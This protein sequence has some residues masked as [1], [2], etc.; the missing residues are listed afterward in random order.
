M[1][2]LSINK[3]SNTENNKNPQFKS[4][5]PVYHWVEKADRKYVVV[6]TKNEIEKMQSKLIRMLNKTLSR[7][8]STKAAAM[9]KV[10]NVVNEAD[11]DYR[12]KSEVR[13]FY[14]PKGGWGKNF[15]APITYLITGKDVTKFDETY[16]K[17][18]GKAKAISKTPTGKYCSLELEE[19]RDN[20]EK[21]GL[22]FVKQ[23]SEKFVKNDDTQSA[24]HIVHAPVFYKKG[25]KKGQVKEYLP[26]WI[27]FR[28]ESGAHN[29]FVKLGLVKQN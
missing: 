7:K 16:G 17:P 11:S 12:I 26:K 2:I 4:A 25:P 9:D 5:Y 3:V 13:S 21:N 28:P 6:V 18:V 27:M 29:P 23:E 1:Q 20:Y 8:D 10:I 22:T 15:F 24:L 14:N 19:A